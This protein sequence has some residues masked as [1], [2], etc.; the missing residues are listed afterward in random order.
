MYFLGRYAVR[1]LI[2]SFFG[3]VSSDFRVR[4]SLIRYK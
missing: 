3:G 2:F 1:L 4:Q